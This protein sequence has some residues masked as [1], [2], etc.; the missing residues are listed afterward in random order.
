M[1]SPLELSSSHLLPS[2][3]QSV[4]FFLTQKLFHLFESEGSCNRHFAKPW[5]SLHL[6][7]PCPCP[8]PT[9]VLSS[10]LLG[11]TMLQECRPLLINLAF[12]R[13][14]S[15]SSLLV[16]IIRGWAPRFCQLKRN[17]NTHKRF[18]QNFDF[19]ER[20]YFGTNKNLKKKNQVS[21]RVAE[22][23]LKRSWNAAYITFFRR[24]MWISVAHGEPPTPTTWQIDSEDHEIWLK[25][26]AHDHN[27]I[28]EWRQ[29]E[30]EVVL[31]CIRIHHIVELVAERVYTM[32]KVSNHKSLVFPPCH[33]KW[34]KICKDKYRGKVWCYGCL[35]TFWSE[36]PVIYVETTTST[37][38]YVLNYVVYTQHFQCEMVFFKRCEAIIASEGR[39][40]KY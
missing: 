10:Q 26:G 14:R 28:I 16:L 2:P 11:I 29:S 25:L 13:Y 33:R 34:S 20:G 4:A 24:R 23:Q 36:Q 7:C 12:M 15:R 27:V 22:T 19:E 9:Y 37:K 18:D 38:I 17:W 5:T 35:C 8:T 32:Q 3:W 21:W 1:A 40:T 31:E 30:F 39:M 6:R